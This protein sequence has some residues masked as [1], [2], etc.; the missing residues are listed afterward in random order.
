VSSYKICRPAAVVTAFAALVAAAAGGVYAAASGAAAAPTA[1]RI[2]LAAAN[3]PIGAKGRTL[4]LSKV[5]IP[6]GVHLA[7]HHHSGTQVAYIARGAL[8]YSVKSGS[9]KVMKGAADGTPKVMVHIS[10]GHTGIIHAGEWIIE[11]PTTIHSA[12]NK[13]STPVVVYLATL[14]PIGSPPA[15]ANK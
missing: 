13:T 9:V 11:Q 4:G 3:N 5:T 14:F 2:A 1:V 15:I 7:L 8:T 6:G 12:T 10:A